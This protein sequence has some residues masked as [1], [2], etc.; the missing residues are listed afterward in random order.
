M[1]PLRCKELCSLRISCTLFLPRSDARN[2][3]R[4]CQKVSETSVNEGRQQRPSPV[5]D[6]LS[7]QHRYNGEDLLAAPQVDACDQHLAQTG[8][9]R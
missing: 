4:R 3:S 8:V 1:V 6:V 5:K 2:V 9:R 7:T